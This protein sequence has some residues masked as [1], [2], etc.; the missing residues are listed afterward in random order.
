[1]PS[2]CSSLASGSS[3][4]RMC[5]SMRH[6]FRGV[7]LRPPSLCP[8][9]RRSQPR[10]PVLPVYRKAWTP[11]RPMTCAPLIM[12]SVPLA[13]PDASSF[14]FRALSHDPTAS[15]PSSRAP[16]SSATPSTHTELTGGVSST[17]SSGTP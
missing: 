6:T 10:T 17:T 11:L 14:S 1:M 2:V 4:R 5:I 13:H 7:A 3:S 16:A 8:Q 15:P 12:F 9:S